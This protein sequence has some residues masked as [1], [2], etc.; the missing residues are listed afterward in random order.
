VCLPIEAFDYKSSNESCSGHG[1]CAKSA[2]AYRIPS[3]YAPIGT[4]Y[5][6][7]PVC[8]C[9]DPGW[10]GAKCEVDVRSAPPDYE[11]WPYALPSVSY[12][13][14]T[15]G[16]TELHLKQ[17]ASVEYGF[18][19]RGSMVNYFDYI[20]NDNPFTQPPIFGTDYLNA[21][22]Q[23]QTA[24]L[25]YVQFNTLN[26]YLVI[27]WDNTFQQSSNCPVGMIKYT[28]TGGPVVERDYYDTAELDYTRYYCGCAI[29]T[30]TGCSN[31]GTCIGGKL[32]HLDLWIS[33]VYHDFGY[34]MAHIGYDSEVAI[35]Q[36]KAPLH[37][38]IM[39]DM[40]YYATIPNE[41]ITEEVS[42][43]DKYH[44]LC[45][46]DSDDYD[47]YWCELSI[48]DQ[49]HCSGHGTYDP[50]TETCTCTL[51]SG[52]MG[53]NCAT[54]FGDKWNCNSHG[55]WDGT[56][57]HCSDPHWWGEH[58]DIECDL[59]HCNGRGTCVLTNGNGDQYD[60]G[61]FRDLIHIT[62]YPG[63]RVSHKC[64]C[65]D[66][67]PDDPTALAASGNH[68]NIVSPKNKI[69]DGFGTPQDIPDPQGR[70]GISQLADQQC[71]VT[72]YT[73]QYDIIYTFNSATGRTV[74]SCPKWTTDDAYNVAISDFNTR[75][76]CGGLERGKC[77]APSETSLSSESVCVCNNGF[78]PPEQ[79][80]GK[81]RCK[82]VNGGAICNGHGTCNID[83]NR[84]ECQQGFVGDACEKYDS[85]DCVNS[86][87]I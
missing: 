67:H 4:G 79:G 78:G 30:R 75:E 2:D 57:C 52:W 58:C 56:R 27:A 64:I 70:N 34:V 74:A 53:P 71:V 41:W 25:S 24:S 15:S 23:R 21:F 85:G 68:C 86:Q 84:C 14:P 5:T 42:N 32:R 8:I 36:E 10:K 29:G 28:K 18:H 6:N 55:F 31:H 73:G 19:S 13:V 87:H 26:D 82:A 69:C 43:Y 20:V 12:T 48:A 50:R 83:N 72:T 33:G 17:A 62:G 37:Y 65:D 3:T 16:L 38:S 7:F 45:L 61:L 51:N 66:K 9:K 60:D 47:G 40:A 46:C 80:C 35:W 77:I 54:P 63:H 22:M 44:P 76:E 81:R 11:T 39:P 59:N 49:V 1:L